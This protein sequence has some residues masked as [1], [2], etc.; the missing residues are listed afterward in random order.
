MIPVNEPLFESREKELLN[1]CIESG[2]VSSEGSL[3][4]DFEKMVAGYTGQKHAV[5][6]SNGTAA[7]E[8]AVAALNLEKGA[9]V[10]MPAFTIIS[11]AL[12]VIRS[13]LRPILVDADPDTWC[14]DVDQATR[15]LK[16]RDDVQA[17]MPVHTYG[18][19]C[20][21]EPLLAT[22]KEKGILVIEDA[23][24]ALGA[25]YSGIKCGAFGD[26]AVLSFYANKLV[27]TG[28]GGMCLTNDDGLDCRLRSL[29]NLYFHPEK[30]FIHHELGFNYR[31]TNLQAAL[32]V[33]QME[34]IEKLIARKKA[35]GETYRRRLSK[36]PG[37]RLQ[38]VP[39]WAEP[40]YWVNGILL[41]DG[42]K[43]DADRLAGELGKKGV[44]TRPFFWPMHL[45][46]IFRK[47][48]LFREETYPVAERLA[49]RGLY[50]PSGMALTAAQIDKV[51]EAVK[52]TLAEVGR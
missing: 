39:S 18:L 21:M 17:I 13:G 12:A 22:A 42:I 37:I 14:M 45:Q 15:L 41:E 16:K 26:I 50:L 28:E 20:N 52:E 35:Q 47:M 2:W 25:T 34:R 46:P 10:L 7:L 4:K 24:E 8:L 43:L 3:V 31:F 27:T 9:G 49:K 36:I 32:G 33:A 5:A 29:R 6:V 51:C 38:A 40:I 48:G 23:A 1:R 44:Q 19:P 11:C 30:R